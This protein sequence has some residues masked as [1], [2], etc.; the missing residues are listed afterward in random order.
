MTGPSITKERFSGRL[1]ID[2]G[3]LRVTCDEDASD[4]HRY[5]TVESLATRVAPFGQSAYRTKRGP[6]LHR[7]R[8]VQLRWVGFGEDRR[9]APS[10][11]AR[12]W[13]GASTHAPVLFLAAQ[14]TGRSVCAKCEAYAVALGEEPSG[15]TLRA[16]RSRAVADGWAA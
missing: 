14:V 13:C 15:L 4:P 7:T 12:W 16:P 3:T 1:L 5:Y 2:Y 9:R 10:F 11:F 8:A 6:V